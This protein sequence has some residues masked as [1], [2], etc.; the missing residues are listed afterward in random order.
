MSYVEYK[1]VH[2]GELVYV[3]V[4]LLFGCALILELALALY[5]T[6][7]VCPVVKEL[8]TFERRCLFLVRPVESLFSKQLRVVGTKSMY[9]VT[10]VVPIMKCQLKNLFS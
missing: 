9:E 5:K 2:K 1:L 7:V 3:Y 6:V 8:K 10:R 4:V